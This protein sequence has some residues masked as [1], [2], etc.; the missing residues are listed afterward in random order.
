MQMLDSFSFQ[1]KLHMLQLIIILMKEKY[2]NC[3]VNAIVVCIKD[4]RK[5]VQPLY[6]VCSRI[7]HLGMQCIDRTDSF[8]LVTEYLYKNRLFILVLLAAG[9]LSFSFH[10]K[11]SVYWTPP[12]HIFIKHCIDNF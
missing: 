10:R 1:F 5:Q 3:F 8:S 11:S 4:G 12:L 2:Q 6:G 7:P 9:V